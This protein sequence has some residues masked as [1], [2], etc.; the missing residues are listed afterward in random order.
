HPRWKMRV[1][2]SF[3]AAFPKLQFI[4]TTHDPLCL[5]GLYEGEIAVFDKN[6]EGRVFALADLPDPGEYRADQLLTS[7]FF[8]L[9]STI[10]EETEKE[11]NE[12]YALLGREENLMNAKE[13]NRL[14]K[15]KMQLRNKKHLGN[16]LREELAFTAIDTLLAKER[17]QEE[18][19]PVAELKDKTISFLEELWN[20]PIDEQLQ[21]VTP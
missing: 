4:V 21:I 13:K 5:K 1:V 9:N 11:F 18:R 3:R 15:L 17:Q 14:K 16:S 19:T 2:N 6:E 10:D 8:G 20:K 12:Y 7:R